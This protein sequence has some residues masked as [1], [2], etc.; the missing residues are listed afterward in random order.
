MLKTFKLQNFKSHRDTT[1]NFSPGVNVIVGEPDKG[2]SNVAKGFYLLREYRPLGFNFCHPFFSDEAHTILRAEFTDGFVELDK[3]EDTAQ[4]TT[5]DDVFSTLNK[6]V[7]DKVTEEINM[8]DINIQKQ[9]DQHFLLTSTPGQIGKTFN[10]VTGLTKLDPAISE[11]KKRINSSNK[12]IKVHKETKKEIEGVLS[13][14]EY[15]DAL[16][17]LVESATVLEVQIDK[18]EITVEQLTDL[19][20]QFMVLDTEIEKIHQWVFVLDGFVD[21]GIHR[22]KHMEELCDNEYALEKIEQEIISIQAKQ[23]KQEILQTM[24]KQLV[25]AE[26]ALDKKRALTTSLQ[27]LEDLTK[28]YNLLRGNI[29]VLLVDVSMYKLVEDAE[30]KNKE[31]NIIVDEFL[32]VEEYLDLLE[33][34]VEVTKKLISKK[35]EYATVIRE[36]G[37]CPTCQSPITEECISRI[38]ED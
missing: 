21:T 36:L 27:S 33:D 23:G 4:Y 30:Q 16:K 31:L 3:T 15:L 38:L 29:E 5:S 25:I 8:N 1:L 37:V 13:S 26:G 14:L 17:Y 11:L 9:L 32:G 22:Y 18:L 28:D 6:T 2:K 7:P 10:A 12:E 19:H 34:V 20:E 35:E 24:G